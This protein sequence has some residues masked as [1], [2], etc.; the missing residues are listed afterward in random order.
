[1][2][3]APLRAAFLLLGLLLLGCNSS[4]DDKS[5][6]VYMTTCTQTFS[7][8]GGDPTGTWTLGSLCMID[9]STVDAFNA[10]LKDYPSCAGAFTEVNVEAGGSVTYTASTY[11]RTADVKTTGKMHANAACFSEMSGGAALS[12]ITCG[13]A[14]SAIPQLF[15]GIT[16]A[17]TY[18]APN[19]LCNC[20]TN[21]ADTIDETGTYTTANGKL[22]E[23]GGNVYEYCV[24]GGALDQKG[25]LYSTSAKTSI[26]GL[27]IF[28]K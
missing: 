3:N 7:A 15:P 4:S 5:A 11:H 24:G 20:T 21:T 10:L 9:G 17:C 23:S 6:P 26:S 2:N 27:A 22:T 1:M 25:T 28:K 19:S 8:C 16:G 12:A 18:D 14:S 13:A